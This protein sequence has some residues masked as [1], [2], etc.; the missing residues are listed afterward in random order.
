MFVKSVMMPKHLSLTIDRNQ[1]VQEALN[2]LEEHGIDGLP[3]LDGEKYFGIITRYNIYEYFFE[4]G[5]KKEEFLQIKSGEIATHKDIYLTG[6]EIFENTL[7]SLKDFPLLA[8]LD[9]NQMFIGIVT[10]FDV[11]EQFQSAFGMNKKG[12]RIAFTAH[13]TE[14]RIARLSE[15]AKQF[16]EH[17]ISIVTFDETDKLIR[18][19]VMKIE[20]KDNI[21]KF[22]Q[23]LE[24]SGFRV[25]DVK[26]D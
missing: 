21:N 9:E 22:I 24:N 5:M 13:E 11:L 25:L 3:V 2:T 14:G 18:R 26:E 4:S 10:R 6:N 20:K 15:I 17:I 12:V 8:V 16:H 1:T 23:K 7:L 19:I